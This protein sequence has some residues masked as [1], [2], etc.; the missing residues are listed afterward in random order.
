MDKHKRLFEML[1]MRCLP[2]GLTFSPR[3]DAFFSTP[4]LTMVV[5]DDHA[6]ALIEHAA[7][8][9]YEGK[10][11]EFVTDD[12]YEYEA[13]YE[14]GIGCLSNPVPLIDALLAAAEHARE[15]EGEK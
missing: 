7:R 11:Y 10:G 13:M 6:H 9:H 14:D 12:G 3:H 15:G 2:P 4:H 8:L 5:N 1:P